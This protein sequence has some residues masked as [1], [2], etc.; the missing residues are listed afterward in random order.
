MKRFILATL[1]WALLAGSNYA[2]NVGIGTATPNAS[3]LLE[4]NDGSRGF[5]MTRV[6]LT[7]TTD[8]TTITSPATGLIVYN[9]NGT[10]DVTPGFYYWD[11]TKWVRLLDAQSDDWKITG[12]TGTNPAVN[13]LG[14]LDNQPLRIRTNNTEH[15]QFTQRGQIEFLNTGGSILIGKDAGANDDFTNNLNVFIGDSAGFSTTTGDENIAI[16]KFAMYGNTTGWRNVA[17]GVSA[18]NNDGGANNVAIG[19]GAMNANTNGKDNVGVGFDALYNNTIGNQNTAVGEGALYSNTTGNSNTALGYDALF[20]NT[21]GNYNIANGMGALRSNTTG[22]YNIAIGDSAAFNNDGN[23]NIAVGSYSLFS[24]TTGNDLIAIGDSALYE[25]RTGAANVALG[26]RALL[27]NTTGT[28]NIANG[29]K[30]LYNNQTGSYNIAIG[31]S[32]LGNNLVGNSNIALGYAALFQN[33]VGDKN[34]AIGDSALY[35][36]DPVSP[37]TGIRNVALGNSALSRIPDGNYN[38]AIGHA[39]MSE[40]FGGDFNTAVGAYAFTF[41]AGAIPPYDNITAIGYQTPVTGGNQVHLGNT[42]VI[43]I[44]GQVNFSTYSDARIKEDVQENVV[45]LPFILRLR[46]V[47]YHLNIHKQNELMGIPDL[48][49]WK[50]KYDIEK[51]TFSGF[52]AQEVKKAAEE[53]GYNFSGVK[54]PRSE[55]DLYKLTY[56]EFVVPLVK[57]VQEQQ[58]IIEQQKRKI[59]ELEKKLEA[60]KITQ[61]KQL[62]DF[63]AE[64]QAIKE[65]LEELEMI[66]KSQAR[67]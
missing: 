31:D 30:A 39:A 62:A 16:G 8:A 33:V 18:L 4:L 42:S 52:L 19:W 64:N 32:A 51:I 23:R 36:H 40:A 15:F 41:G 26:T 34:I 63:K 17:I 37:G 61:D 35:S 21:S 59:Q 54:E 55:R 53:T 6:A 49:E 24:N 11:G 58:E 2:Q 3:A 47:T 13:F 56:A 10:A 29:Y 45:G 9:T 43:E 14:T 60:Q 57:A 12:N 28:Y 66:L 5:L 7:S 44:A 67:K 48:G 38:V 25:N 22:S 27:N 46:P 65:R 20:N 1:I 50:G